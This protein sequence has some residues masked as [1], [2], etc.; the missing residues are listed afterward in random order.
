[1]SAVVAVQEVKAETASAAALAT[2]VLRAIAN[3]RR[4]FIVVYLHERGESSVSEMQR[5]TGLSQSAL[6]QHLA[7]MRQAGV[8]KTRRAAQT[9]YYRLANIGV[10]AVVMVAASAG[11][12]IARGHP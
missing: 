12:R 4:A 5:A 10:A 1:M 6:S 11:D 2:P 8:V 3:D 9:V 7:K